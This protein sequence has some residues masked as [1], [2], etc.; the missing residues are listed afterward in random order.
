MTDAPE[1]IQEPAPVHPPES[2]SDLLRQHPGLVLAGGLAAGLLAGALLP[3]RAGGKLAG[4]ALSV[5]AMAGELGLALSRQARD[6][7]GDVAQDGRERLGDLGTH[8]AASGRRAAHRASAAGDELR[9]TGIKLARKAV[10]LA[11]KSSR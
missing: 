4:R 1:A 6:R 8:A 7:A 10:E 3:R 5:A 11:T 2:L 9:R